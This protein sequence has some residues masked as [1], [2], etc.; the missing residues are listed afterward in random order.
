MNIV[1][2]RAIFLTAGFMILLSNHVYAQSQSQSQPFQSG[3]TNASLANTISQEIETTLKK[4]GDFIQY[5]NLAD[6]R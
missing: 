5:P 6:A 2:Y 4:C 1:F 3:G